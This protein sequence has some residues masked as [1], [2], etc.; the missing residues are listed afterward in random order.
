MID[1]R[2]LVT[3]LAAVAVGFAAPSLPPVPL[4]RTGLTFRSGDY[5][6]GW[7]QDFASKAFY[8][9]W[10]LDAWDEVASTIRHC[11]TGLIFATQFTHTELLLPAAMTLPTDA[12][13]IDTIGHAA[14]LASVFARFRR[15]KHA[16]A[17][18][19]TN[20]GDDEHRRTITADAPPLPRV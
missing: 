7:K 8:S 16:G 19:Y 14:D 18:F 20:E 4:V 15:H 5:A 10:Q 13:M 3:G 2:Q 9:L 6:Y 11:D 1:R 12:E 17:F